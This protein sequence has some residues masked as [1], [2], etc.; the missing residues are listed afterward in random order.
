MYFIYLCSYY[1]SKEFQI[2]RQTFGKYLTF[3]IFDDAGNIYVSNTCQ[4]PAKHLRRLV[5]VCGGKCTSIE[6]M[7]DVVVGYTSRMYNNVNEKWILDCVTE[8]S[9]INISS[10]ALPNNNIT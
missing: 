10:Y 4:P 7:A 6:T 3:H 1:F 8:G 5:R 9:L 2:R